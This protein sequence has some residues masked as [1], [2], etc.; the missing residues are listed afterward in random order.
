MNDR[1]V[2]VNISSNL[3]PEDRQIELDEAVEMALLIMYQPE[4]WSKEELKVCRDWAR[5]AKALSV[6]KG[7]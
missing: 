4:P 6:A 1:D 5:L 3:I 7:I 2:I